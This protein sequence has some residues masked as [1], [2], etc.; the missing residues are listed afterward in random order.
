MFSKFRLNII[1][2]I[3]AIFLSL[4]FRELFILQII[5]TDENTQ[6]IVNQNFETYYIPAPRGEII[7]ING[8]KLAQSF[9]EPYLFLNL[10]KINEENKTVYKQ[11]ISFNF[12]E[13]TNT[14]ID[15]FFNSNELFVEIVNLNDYQTDLRIKIQDYEAFEIFNQPKR[16]Y[17]YKELFSHVI[18]YVGKPNQE[19]L[20]EYS[21]AFGNKIVGKNGLERYYENILSGKPSEITLQNGEII[22]ITPAIPGQDIQ[23]TIDV[24]A[25]EVVKESLQQGI[26]L[27]NKSFETINL[28]ERG[29]VVVQKIDTGEITAMVSLP[30][31]DPNQFVSGISE[32]EF[33]KLNR[34]QA[35]NNFAIQGLYPPGSVFKVVA[36]WLAVNEGIFPEEASNSDQYVNCEGSLS[37]GFDD[38]SK[39]VYQDWKPEGHGK[40]NLSEALKQSCNVY[41]WDIALKIWRTFGNTDSEAMLQEYSKKLGFSSMSNIDL[42]FEREGVIPDRQLFEDWKISKPE[43]VRPEGWLGGDLMNLIIGQGAITTTPIQVSN[44]YRTLMT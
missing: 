40:V 18:G 5:N 35:F 36:Y 6:D 24:N 19:E 9:L 37:F 43:L 22:D 11:F 10:K 3:F 31:F 27:A 26:V 28:I 29:A 34:T 32:F 15:N 14:E 25:Q 38:G 2:I 42:P 8:N 7:D 23:I 20:I 30:D 12:D 1:F 16:L 13:L 33:K 44:A 41:F 21:N 17:I 4:I 39:Q